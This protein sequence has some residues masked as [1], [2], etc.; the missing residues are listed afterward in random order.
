[1]RKQL[2]DVAVLGMLM[3]LVFIVIQ[4]PR[5]NQ[6]PP[7]SAGKETEY[8]IVIFQ[9]NIENEKLIEL[10]ATQIMRIKGN[11]PLELRLD[12]PEIP[13]EELPIQI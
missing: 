9:G 13:R 5:F 2:L 7:V 4:R 12:P 8:T 11:V 1:M 3:L 6:I 10:G